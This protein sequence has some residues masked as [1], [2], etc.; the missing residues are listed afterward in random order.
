V[1]LSY[2]LYFD[3]RARLTTH[4]A[5][6]AGLNGLLNLRRISARRLVRQAK[7][8]DL[9]TTRTSHDRVFDYRGLGYLIFIVYMQAAKNARRHRA[10]DDVRERKGVGVWSVQSLDSL[11][12]PKR[13][14]DH[15]S[16]TCAG[17]GRR[18]SVQ[19]RGTDTI[20][21]LDRVSQPC[22]KCRGTL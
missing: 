6:N 12:V 22:R 11:S 19:S 14:S 1:L 15:R 7:H 4:G 21:E 16:T 20:V 10:E 5:P 13:G 8:H 2:V 3:A 9:S 17:R 18:G